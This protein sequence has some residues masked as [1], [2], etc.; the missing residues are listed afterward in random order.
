MV[1]VRGGGSGL[2]GGCECGLDG[3]LSYHVRRKVRG[4]GD[5]DN[6][7]IAGSSPTGNINRLVYKQ[8][9]EYDLMSASP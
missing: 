5:L 9:Y 1:R 2:I 7:W 4:D 3:V 6:E 8:S